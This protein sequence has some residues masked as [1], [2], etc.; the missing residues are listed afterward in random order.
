VADDSGQPVAKQKGAEMAD[1][2]T[3]T[4]PAAKAD[5]T[6]TPAADVAKADAGLQVVVYDRDGVPA[7]AALDKITKAEAGHV[8]VCDSHGSPVG[9]VKP[10]EVFKADA[11]PKAAQVAVY[12]QAGDLVGICDPADITP[13][14]GAKAPA[15]G[16]EAKDDGGEKPKADA[17]AADPADLTPAP[18]ADAGTPADAPAAPADDEDVA[19]AEGDAPAD[20]QDKTQDV[21]DVLKSIVAELVTEK[22][23]EQAPAEDVA[24]S[25]VAGLRTQVEE[26]LTRIAKVELLDAPPKVFTNGQ[27]PQLRGQDKGALPPFDAEQARVRKQELYAADGP[28]QARI[29]REMQ[30]AAIDRYA[31]IRAGN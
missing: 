11:E 27:T 23:A 19:K 29:A 1:S 21:R 24:K 6:E 9:L 14:Q 8:L 13:I 20:G 2:E 16:D 5:G 4:E 18:P 26:A 25:D 15:G 30:Q 3:A 10:G 7:Q 12:N 17:P 31:Q 22:L 28:D